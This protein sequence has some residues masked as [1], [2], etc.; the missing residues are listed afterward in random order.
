MIIF[1]SYSLTICF[2]IFES[3]LNGFVNKADYKKYKH[4]QLRLSSHSVALQVLGTKLQDKCFR[5]S[6][7]N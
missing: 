6:L 1:K 7:K 2:L 4:L 5:L 3:K